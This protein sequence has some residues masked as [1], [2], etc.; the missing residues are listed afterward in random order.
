MTEFVFMA[1]L[2]G[3]LVIVILGLIA[4]GIYYRDFEQGAL[5]VCLFFGC[6]VFTLVAIVAAT[7]TNA[8]ARRYD[9][10]QQQRGNQR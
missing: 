9:A 7:E 6:A 10:M 8:A 3:F 5:S 2:T 4:A 1:C